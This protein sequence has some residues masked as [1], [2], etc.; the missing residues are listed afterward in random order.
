VSRQSSAACNECRALLGGYVLSALGPDEGDA[1]RAH[2]AECAECAAEYGQ[3]AGIPAML[4]VAGAGE[5]VAEVPP[6]AL[7]EAVLDRFAREHRDAGEAGGASAAAAPA[8][9]ER[10]ARSEPRPPGTRARA[11]RRRLV[12]P[13]PAAI[14]G[15][16]AAAAVTAAVLILPADSG[17]RGGDGWGATYRARLA[18]L[19][20]APDAA[21]S[22]KLT[23]SSSG[24]YVRLHVTGLHGTPDT[25]YE[26]WCLRDDGEK[27][28]AGT[29]RTD[30]DGGADVHLTTA[31]VPGEYHRLS[32]ERKVF[33]PRARP[34]E[35]VMAGEILYPHG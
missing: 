12:R 22:A 8:T 2:L 6:A 13:L 23:T 35:R 3:L 17:D 30:A 1:V 27:V 21:A 31:A 5:N 16:L 10:P 18:G 24:T 33:G 11:L 7:E 34:G 14:A 26:L 4:D 25:V 19:A 28:S 20:P 9:R 29:F 15:A 32:V